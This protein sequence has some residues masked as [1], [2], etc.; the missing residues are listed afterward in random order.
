MDRSFGDFLKTDENVP[1]ISVH[2]N[3]KL[4]P[5]DWQI[6]EILL[7]AQH[8]E[9]LDKLPHEYGRHCTAIRMDVLLTCGKSIDEIMASIRRMQCTAIERSEQHVRW[10]SCPMVGVVH[11]PTELTKD[12]SIEFSIAAFIVEITAELLRS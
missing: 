7:R 9:N 8:L 3:K 2:G 4:K 10:E 5:H 6:F 11:S 1:E 12:S